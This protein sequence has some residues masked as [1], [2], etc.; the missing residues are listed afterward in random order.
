MKD[1]VQYYTLNNYVDEERFWTQECH[2]L[3]Y[4]AISLI[5][6]S[7]RLGGGVGEGKELMY[8]VESS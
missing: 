5:V 3:R 4:W 8:L 2:W 7:Y 6:P 1:R